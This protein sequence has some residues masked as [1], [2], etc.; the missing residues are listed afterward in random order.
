M[1][2]RNH[3]GNARSLFY[4]KRTRGLIANSQFVEQ[5]S[6]ECWCD[7][8]AN[9]VQ[10]FIKRYSRYSRYRT[11]SHDKATISHVFP[12]YSRYQTVFLKLQEITSR[13]HICANIICRYG[14]IRSRKTSDIVIFGSNSW[15]GRNL[16]T[17]SASAGL[18][19]L[20]GGSIC[21]NS[22]VLFTFCRFYGII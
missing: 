15:K 5:N 8:G 18:F 13:H 22:A 6:V 4:C 17:H 12:R 2:T 9:L 21:K 16:K 3:C 7:L 10:H 11:K 1:F 14:N 20:L 19:V